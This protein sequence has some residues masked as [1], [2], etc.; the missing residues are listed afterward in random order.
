MHGYDEFTYHRKVNVMLVTCTFVNLYIPSCLGSSQHVCY[1]K[2][3]LTWYVCMHIGYICNTYQSPILKSLVKSNLFFNIM[4]DFFLSSEH[5]SLPKLH[6][7]LPVDLDET[8]MSIQ[9]KMNVMMMDLC[10]LENTCHAR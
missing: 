1:L 2:E 7:S 4:P 10:L 3:L 5:F 6:M 9:G 8:E